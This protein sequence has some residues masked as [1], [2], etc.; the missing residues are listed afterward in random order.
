MDNI[1]VVE[2]KTE[3]AF[4]QQVVVEMNRGQIRVGPEKTS[5]GNGKPFGEQKNIFDN[6]DDLSTLDE[7]LEGN[8]AI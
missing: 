1:E 4:E 5:I 2:N 7:L 6:I 3:K 8:V